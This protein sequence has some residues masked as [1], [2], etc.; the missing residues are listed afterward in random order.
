MLILVTGGF[1]SVGLSIIN[2]L[3]L[4]GHNVRVLELETKKTQKNVKQYTDRIEVLWGNLLEPACLPKAVENIDVVVHLA[5]VLPPL[6]ETNKEL[7]FK[8]NVEGTHNLLRAIKNSKS[9]PP[10]IFASSASVMGPTQNR[11]PP[12][13][14]YDTPN[15]T[16]NYTQSKVQVEQE[17]KTSGLRYCICRFG[18]V[19]P[20][21]KLADFSLIKNAFDIP[22]NARVEMVLDLDVAVAISNAAELM[23]SGDSL[24][25]K[26]INIAGGKANGFQ[27][28]GRDLTQ[29][30]FEVMGI[31]K[32]DENRFTKNEYFLDWLDTEESQRLLNYQNHTYEQLLDLYMKPY[33]KYRPFFRLFSPII[34]WYLERQSPYQS[35]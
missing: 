20:T 30:I 16:T 10:L 12:I 15:P 28:Y 11:A 23:I 29:A 7:C 5:G 26:I 4:R 6:T 19:L 3:L 25:G 2:E 18:A 35:N 27:R 8:V 14:A 9:Q 24:D 13:S 32:L 1:G 34:R 33:K 21:Q 31:G 22:L 17:L